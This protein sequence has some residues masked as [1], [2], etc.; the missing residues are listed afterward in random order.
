M[1]EL[2]KGTMFLTLYADDFI[3]FKSFQY[4]TNYKQADERYH[5][6]LVINALNS[7]YTNCL[8]KETVNNDVIYFY[9]IPSL[10][11]NVP[12]S[13]RSI[14]LNEKVRMLKHAN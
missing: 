8:F 9:I 4:Q 3:D 10:P 7:L 1:G 2:G 11:I 13:G 5:R 14:W 12:K 6:L